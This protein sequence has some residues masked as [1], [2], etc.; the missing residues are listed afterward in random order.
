[1][2]T[3]TLTDSQL[4]SLPNLQTNFTNST[5]AKE[6]PAVSIIA[7]ENFFS[8]CIIC[9]QIP[10]DPVSLCN[11]TN[12]TIDERHLFCR[13]CTVNY[14]N[15]KCPLCNDSLTEN[16]KFIE[17]IQARKSINDMKCNVIAICP[18]KCGNV[19]LLNK[20]ETHLK[21]CDGKQTLSDRKLSVVTSINNVTQCSECKAKLTDKEQIDLAEHTE[22]CPEE[23]A[24]YKTKNSIFPSLAI[25]KRLFNIDKYKEQ[26]K[27]CTKVNH[28]FV[29]SKKLEL[30]SLPI[31]EFPLDNQNLKE[32][33]FISAE[34]TVSINE[35]HLL[36]IT[37]KKNDHFSLNQETH[38][39]TNKITENSIPKRFRNEQEI[40][41]IPSDKNH[42]DL[43]YRLSIYAH[44]SE[45][46]SILV[47]QQAFTYSSI[48][49]LNSMYSYSKTD[50]PQSF[51]DVKEFFTN[52]GLSKLYT[53]KLGKSIIWKI[54]LAE[55]INKT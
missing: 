1:M 22:I 5:F 4:S 35:Q 34:A 24:E 10:E 50:T 27:S 28:N 41:F 23:F 29:T 18:K 32:I 12:I 46:E 39:F 8:K 47:C 26:A 30:I 51:I 20:M 38:H 37:T 54:E 55:T 48:S 15:S 31:Y 44:L 52:D 16:I 42:P 25:R 13:K 3:L 2:N 17:D 19:L 45:R 43:N 33:Q 40:G 14:E 21:I 7:S 53:D 6:Y 9:L 11:R 49:T 36:V